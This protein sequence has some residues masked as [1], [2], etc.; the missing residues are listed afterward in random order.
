MNTPLI[1]FGTGAFAGVV[2]T[3]FREAGLQIA[4]FTVDASAIEANRTESFEGL[5]VVAFETVERDFDPQQFRMFIAV[6]YSG[7]NAVRQ[8]KYLAAKAKGYQ[9]ISFVHRTACVASNARFG[10]NCL[11]LEQVVL[12]PDVTIGD[13]VLIWTGA[14]IFHHTIV[15]DHCFIGGR[16]VIAGFSRI[17]EA[18]FV[19]TSAIIRDQIDIPKGSIIG[20]GAV[21]LKGEKEAMVYR[22]RHAEVISFDDW[23]G[24]I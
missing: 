9:F 14:A 10:E 13:N 2:S 24:T 4:A 19:G 17:G 8:R 20:A 16:S 22:A 1:I 12:Q 6:G 23:Q 15:E 18:S 3:L 5:P 21:V 11:I 7:K